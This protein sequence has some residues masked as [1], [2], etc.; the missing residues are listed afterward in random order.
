MTT[1]LTT[2]GILEDWA[3]LRQTKPAQ[4]LEG[5]RAKR[6]NARTPAGPL[7]LALGEQGA[8]RLLVPITSEEAGTT[9]LYA[10]ESLVADF[11][12]LLDEGGKRSLFLDIT[13]LHNNLEPVFAEVIFE[14]IKRIA[15]GSGGATAAAEVIADFRA[16]LNPS[17]AKEVDKSKV[18][19]LI[20]ELL[21][22][23]MLL[24]LHPSSWTCWMGPSGNRHDFRRG[25]TSMEVKT[26]VSIDSK[27]TIN[28]F[29]QLEIPDD[30]ELY[31]HHFTLET[32]ADGPLTVE[33][34]VAHAKALSSAPD[35]IGKL[36]AEMGCD[37]PS[38][39]AW[40]ALSFRRQ[41]EQVYK[42]SDNFPRICP[43]L[44]PTDLNVKSLT[45]VEYSISVSTLDAFL[46]DQ[47]VVRELYLDLAGTK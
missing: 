35:E 47:N 31:L 30:T 19:G 41:G 17:S 12:S 25:S 36:L 27:L 7:R 28:G 20:G 29:H 15:G 45:E 37:D 9:T 23:N 14:V 42:I 18:V 13:C 11:A 24:E 4:D 44:L 39:P 22:L 5:I 2:L 33:A 3:K 34:L 38:A 26:S 46:C 43:S 16:L 21:A 32:V 1:A 40:N 8:A 6:L 10:G